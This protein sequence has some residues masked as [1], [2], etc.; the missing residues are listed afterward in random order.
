LECL[1]SNGKQI[2]L[3]KKKNSL[4]STKIRQSKVRQYKND[5]MKKDLCSKPIPSII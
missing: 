2:I 5:L 4:E 3:I 1:K